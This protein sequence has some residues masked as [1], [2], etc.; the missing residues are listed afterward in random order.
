MT[1]PEPA[2]SPESVQERRDRERRSETREKLEEHFHKVVQ[3]LSPEEKGY[4]SEDRALKVTKLIAFMEERADRT[5]AS[6]RAMAGFVRF[7]LRELTEEEMQ[8]VRK[9]VRMFTEELRRSNQ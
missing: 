1:E 9:A 3:D 7:C 4:K 2:V 8:P 6:L 5:E